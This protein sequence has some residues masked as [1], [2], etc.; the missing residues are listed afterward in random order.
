M[1]KIGKIA[2]N[3][4]LGSF[5]LIL[6]IILFLAFAIRTASFQTYLGN[7]ASKYL[8]EYLENEI[9]IER[10]DI[11]FFD[12]VF[13]ESVYVS[14]QKMDTLIHFEELAVNFDLLGFSFTENHFPIDAVRLQKPTF[15]LRKYQGDE[16]SNMQFI[17]DAFKTDK[18]KEP[19]DF[20]INISYFELIDAKF[21]FGDWNKPQKLYGIDFAH[22]NAQSINLNAQ[23]IAISPTVYS[24]KISSLSLKDHAGFVLNQLSTNAIFSEKGL[25]MMNTTISTPYSNLV[26]PKLEMITVNYKSY[27]Y[28]LDEVDLNIHLD[29]SFVSFTDV[30]YFAPT[31][32]GMRDTIQF[33][34][35]TRGKIADWQIKDVDLRFGKHS[36]IR[37]DFKLPDFREEVVAIDQEIQFL[38]VRIQ[39]V[40]QFSLPESG[41]GAIVLPGEIQRL[42][43]IE[44]RDLCI[45]GSLD[46]IRLTTRSL[47]TDAGEIVFHETIRLQN[48]TNET[49]LLIQPL[50]QNKQFIAL[51]GFELGKVLDVPKLNKVTGRFSF[52]ATIDPSNNVNIKN[53]FANFSR[54]DFANY[55]YNFIYIPGINVDVDLRKRAAQTSIEGRLFVRD[56]NLDLEFKGSASFGNFFDIDAFL[57]LQCAHL[58]DV[59]Q[60]LDG[61]G[62]LATKFHFKGRGNDIEDISF[63]TNIHNL[64]YEENGQNFSFNH[65][66]VKLNRK[67]G[68]DLLEINSDLLSARVEGYA[69]LR[70]I[71]DNILFQSAKV[72]PALFTDLKPVFDPKSKLKY[73]FD[74]IAIN[75]V[76]AIF[77][78][79][80]RIAN[81]TSLTGSY[82][83]S[84]NVFDLTVNSQY[85][86]F[87]NYQINNIYLFQELDRGQ[88]L[89][90]YRTDEFIIKDSVVLKSMRSTNLASRGFMDSQLIFD[91][92]KGY[93]SNLQWNTHIFEAAGFDIDFLPSYFTVND[94]RWDL[95]QLAHLNYSGDCFLI[96]NF[97]L[98]RRNQIVEIF[99]QISS[100]PDDRLNINVMNLDLSDVGVFVLPDNNMQGRANVTG[101]IQE[102]FTELK[103]SGQSFIN[104]L[105]I[106]DRFIGDIGFDAYFDAE[107]EVIQMMGELMYLERRTFDFKGSYAIKEDNPLDYELQFNNTDLGIVNVFMDPQVVDGI[108]GSLTGKFKL[109]GSFKEPSVNGKI[110]L[111]DGKF[112]LALLGADFYYSGNIE[113]NDFGVFINAMPISD[114]EGNTGF[115]AGHLFHNN[116]KDF[117]YEITFDFE[118]HPT[119]RDPN[120]P[121]LPKKLDRFKV[122]KS[123]YEEDVLYYGDAFVTGRASISGYQDQMSIRVDAK[124]ERGTWINFPMYGPASVSEDGFI[125]FKSPYE[126]AIQEDTPINFTGVDLALNFEITPDAQVKLIFDDNVGDEITAFGKGNLR[127]NLDNYGDIA[128]NGTYTVTDGVYNFVMGPYRQNFYIAEGGTVQWTGSPYNAILDLETY[129]RTN[130]NLAVVMGDVVTQRTSEQEEIRSILRLKG[131][132]N[133]PDITFDLDAPRASESGRAVINRIRSDQDELNRQFFSLLI[134]RRFQPLA[135]QGDRGGAGGGAAFDLVSTQISSLLSQV[136]DDVDLNFA[137]ASDEMTGESSVEFGF[138]KGLMDD[139]LIVSGAF[140]VGAYE[141]AGQNHVIG[142]VNIEYLL[143]DRGTFRANVFNESNANSIVHAVGGQYT[144]GIGINYQEEFYTIKDFQAFKEFLNLFRRVENR[145]HKQSRYLPVPKEKDKKDT[146]P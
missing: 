141:A 35:N 66:D 137:M 79:Q 12:R 63:S 131:D 136:S 5:E 86:K 119:K 83:G 22:L 105:S 108:E 36:Q 54:F 37:G 112:N 27:K 88:L 59:H 11:A 43:T 62:E 94:H 14:D 134:W 126:E 40:E 93:R 44:A 80:L 2:W 123:R 139:R 49:P 100:V 13:V 132:M 95:K 64:F 57:D 24:A 121:L 9:T 29:T 4:F 85:V 142:D 70:Y 82:D 116:F 109:T 71:F 72:F 92:K 47:K 38:S 128:L 15:N 99:G 67:K 114:E 120:N 144:Q 74:I 26:L 75:D 28:F 118:N 73:D 111:N 52:A 55:P 87:D 53:I 97:R 90:F 10:I 135:G 6:V 143:N 8:S 145:Q 50:F 65:L 110:A 98:E 16:V 102:P 19:V 76:L 101:F 113:S 125:R 124:T 21:E 138:Q 1:A 34:A 130:A 23:D 117:L 56:P 17:V 133:K 33:I 18:E 39:D 96:D 127:V 68:D 89:A 7:K 77:Y 129:Y 3:L 61:R 122:M 20:A 104:D 115:L 31:L 60:T 41:T 51:S 48:L 42:G 103:F 32:K 106:D 46:D 78:P 107:N 81:N 140:G 91:D 146:F 84:K 25:V 69:D 30:S 58:G 45:S